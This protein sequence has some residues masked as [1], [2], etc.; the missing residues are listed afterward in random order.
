MKRYGLTL[1]DWQAILRRQGFGCA[2]CGDRDKPVVTD[3]EH[4]RGWAKM[5]PEERKTFVRGLLCRFC[6]HRVVG[7]HKR[8]EPLEAAAKYLR[9]YLKRSGR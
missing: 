8:P 6:N 3:H 2:V 1:D 9:A 4:V 5:P 7:N